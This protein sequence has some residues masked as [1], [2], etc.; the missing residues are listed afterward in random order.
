MAKSVAE[1]AERIEALEHRVAALEAAD[2]RRHVS[3]RLERAM[4]ALPAPTPPGRG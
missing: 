2:E 3:Q 1:L 4:D